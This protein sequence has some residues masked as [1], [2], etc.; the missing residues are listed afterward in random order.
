[1]II[2]DTSIWIE[3][4]RAREPYLSRVAELLAESRILA[5][6]TVFGELLQGARDTIERDILVSFWENVPR[7]DM[8]GLLIKAGMRSSIERWS[9]KGVGL[10]DAS[11][12][13]L[14]EET[15]A[16]VWTLDKRLRAILP[17]KQLY[18]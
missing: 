3:F 12:A 14:A 17:V 6:E 15:G 11:I 10:V 8:P 9:A 16:Q 1:M 2:L 7:Q 13:V 5:T 4:L 18:E